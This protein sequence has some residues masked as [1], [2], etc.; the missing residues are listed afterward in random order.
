M[1]LTN[2]EPSRYIITFIKYK[3]KQKTTRWVPMFLIHVYCIII[4]TII[5]KIVCTSIYYCK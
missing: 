3:K 1:G 2:Q 5:I 4:I